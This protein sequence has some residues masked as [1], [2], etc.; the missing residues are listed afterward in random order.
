MEISL[1]GATEPLCHCPYCLH[2][3]PR[4]SAKAHAETPAANVSVDR[5]ERRR[6]A[7]E[8][9]VDGLLAGAAEG[10]LHCPSCD[11]R[12]NKN[13]ELAL[14]NAE[15]FSCPHCDEDLAEQAYRAVAYDESRWLPVIASLRA[16]S[17][18]AACA[19]CEHCAYRGAVAM[20][21]QRA[22]SKMNRAFPSEAKLLDRILSRARWS[23]PECDWSIECEAAREY[24]KLAAEGIALL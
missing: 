11:E 9:F 20:A 3:Q 12:L 2:V 5:F 15:N 22:L 1:A 19:E 18:A 10:A 21:C 4:E 17:D 6:Q 16:G 23:L 14:R 24:R 13:D 8:R 7:R